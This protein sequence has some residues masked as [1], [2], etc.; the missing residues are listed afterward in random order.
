MKVK[1]LIEILNQCNSN[2]EIKVLFPLPNRPIG[3]LFQD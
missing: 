2:A 3:G 1:E